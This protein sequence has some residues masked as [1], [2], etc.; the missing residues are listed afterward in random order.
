[1]SDQIAQRVRRRDT[2]ADDDDDDPF[3]ALM[4][5]DAEEFKQLLDEA[6]ASAAAG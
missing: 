1:M 3:D 5:I 2:M 6:P 4:G